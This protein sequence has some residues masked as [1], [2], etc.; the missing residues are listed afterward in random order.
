M[1]QGDGLHH[2]N[3]GWHFFHDKTSGHAD[4]RRRRRRHLPCSEKLCHLARQRIVLHRRPG[5]PVKTVPE[6]DVVDRCGA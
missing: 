3:V 6:L 5:V 4:G 2:G 1:S